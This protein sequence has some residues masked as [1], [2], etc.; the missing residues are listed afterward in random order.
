M[1]LFEFKS[2]LTEALSQIHSDSS[3]SITFSFRSRT[4]NRPW[5]NNARIRPCR[6]PIPSLECGSKCR[7]GCTKVRS[8]GKG[9]SNVQP[10][11]RVFASISKVEGM[12]FDTGGHVN[13]AVTHFSQVWKLPNSEQGPKALAYAPLVLAQVGY[14]CGMRPDIKPGDQ[15]VV[16]GDGLV[17]H[18]AAQTLLAR[19]AK[20]TVLGRRDERLALLPSNIQGVNITIPGTLEGLDHLIDIQVVVD[21]VGAMPVFHVL[22]PRMK[23]NSHLVSAGFLG[24]NGLID[25]QELRPQE[26]TLH[27]PSGWTAERMD[28]TL[29]AIADGRLTT[30]PLITQMFP[31]VQGKKAW[32]MI[33]DK[34]EAFLGVVLDWR[35]RQQT[36]AFVLVKN[37]ELPLRRQPKPGAPV[38]VFSDADKNKPD[39]IEYVEG[40]DYT[41]DY[42]NASIRRTTDS[43]IA[44][45]SQHLMYGVINFDHTEFGDYSNSAYTVYAEYDYTPEKVEIDV[46]TYSMASGLA[47]LLPR[48][49]GKLQAGEEAV[50]VVYG[51]SISTGGEAS[52]EKFMYFQRFT[53]YVR[54]LFPGG[55]IRIVNKAIAGETSE[56]GAA[57]VDSDVVPLQPDL[58][59]IGYGMNDQNLYE[60]GIGVS[61]VD[62]ER[63]LRHII[64]AIRSNGDADIVLVTPCEPNPL[65]RHTSG[66]MD[67]YSDVIHRLGKQYGLGVA[68]VQVLWKQELAAGK[69]PESLLLNNINHPNDY[70]H[71]L[72]FTAFANMISQDNN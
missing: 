43:R 8:I 39:L 41:V 48:V 68:D 71:Y 55:S 7:I 2:A 33:T 21:S 40:T 44:D 25:I 20:V 17:G 36:E 11:D 38:R 49:A 56:G 72:Y 18:W 62:Y 69:T 4:I 63:N 64:E 26:I 15:A 3:V 47:T 70:G 10:G 51:D 66:A 12:A 57:R 67:D 6:L 23:L 35:N 54:E 14:N 58:V 34:S 13:P 1:E 61:P 59:S 42:I 9:V 5:Y 53:N 24:N 32:Q 22:R 45:W 31:A 16:I 50:Y 37:E 28:E 60:H 30:L 19:G 46:G 65:W 52:Q 29:A 27:S